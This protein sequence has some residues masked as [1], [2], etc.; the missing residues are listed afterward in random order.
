MHLFYVTPALGDGPRYRTEGWSSMPGPHQSVLPTHLATPT[1]LS[2][3]ELMSR[4]SSG[5]V[6]SFVG[7]YD[8][9]R[10]RAYRTARSVCHDDGCAQEAVQEGFLSVW[11]SRA[12]YH[13]ER[14]SV[15]AWVLTVIR[16]RAID[17][18]RS[19]HRH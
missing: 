4:V 8:R 6:D 7:L 3:R 15:A 1:L 18:A 5:S 17:V 12:S 10:D 16:Y 13:P 14:G 9:F 2:D 19:N 11:N